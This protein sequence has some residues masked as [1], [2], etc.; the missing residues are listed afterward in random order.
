MACNL[1]VLQS[2]ALRVRTNSK[3]KKNSDNKENEKKR[4]PTKETRLENLKKM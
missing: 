4:E 2:D 3:T 1:Y